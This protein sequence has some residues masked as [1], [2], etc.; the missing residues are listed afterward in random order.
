VGLRTLLH[1]VCEDFAH[2]ST[3][4][5]RQD[6]E[7]RPLPPGEHG[8]C[9]PVREAI[10]LGLCQLRFGAVESALYDTILA[11]VEPRQHADP[12]RS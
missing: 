3:R 2:V 8:A 12:P 1:T 5:Q 6:P 9:H 7:G 10:W 11:R 4:M